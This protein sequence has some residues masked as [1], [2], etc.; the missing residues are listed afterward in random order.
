VL[1]LLRNLLRRK[2]VERDLDEELRATSELLVEEKLRAGMTPEQARRAARLELGSTESLKD[3]VRDV[4]AGAALDM[5]GQDVRY[6]LRLF[7]RAPGFTVV[8]ILTLALGIGANAAIFGVVKSVLVDAL[9]YADADRLVRVYAHLKDGSFGQIQLHAG[10]YQ[11]LA[12]RQRSFDSLAA[13][14]TRRDAVLGGEE[15][16]RVVT[17]QWV[18]PHL[19]RTLGVTAA[20]GRTFQYEDRAL[21]HV[22]ASGAELG[23]DTARSVLITHAAWQGLFAGDPDIVGR[24]LRVNALPRTVIGVLP[25]GF[26]GPSGR[27]DLY[28]AFDIQPALSRGSNWLNLV[29]RL[30]PGVAV[31][32]AQRDVVALWASRQDA[33]FFANVDMAAVPLRD[34]LLGN[35][36]TPLLVL[37]ASAALVLLIACSNLAGALLSRS[38]A[39]R[40]ELAV[41]AALGAGRRRLVRQLLTESTLLALCGGAAGLLLAQLLLSLLRGL[42]A[43]VLPAYARLSLDGGA[44]LVMGLVAICTGLAFGIVPA[45]SLGRADSDGALREEARGASEGR[46]P[47]RLRGALVA[48]QIAL[49]ASLLAGAGLLGRSLWRIAT[50]PLG[51]DARSVLTGRF[52]LSIPDYP[53]P[54]SRA[55]IHE[56]LAE[57]LRS[58]PGVEHVAIAHK[59]PTIDPRISSLAPE[60]APPG[61]VRPL[62]S[63][64][65]V[66]D[67][68]FR[69]LRIPLRAGRGFDA[70]DRESGPGVAVVSESTA[71]RFWPAGQALGAGVRVDGELLSIVGVV[72]DV[73]NDLARAESALMVYRSH[74]QESTQRFVVLIRARDPLA[75]VRPL[76][77]EVKALDPGLPV[78]QP[79]TLEAALGEGLAARR[80]PV[81][82]L[83]GFGALALLLASIGVY[84]MFANLAAARERE[85]GVRIALGSTPGAIALLLLR[86]GAG[87][88]AAG[89]AGGALG[90]ALVARLVRGWLYGI[91]AL[92][93]L[94][95]GSAVALLM[96]C[97]AIALL[98]PVQR[99]TR[100]D[101]IAALR[102]D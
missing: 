69:T 33:S 98:I 84:G 74:R 93:P 8:A 50:A 96:G 71:R 63:Y 62:V 95:L 28:F 61:E 44:V 78:Q 79:M 18:E 59:L 86:Q 2:R 94:A 21:G 42:A 91:E 82:L 32:A 64:A 88:M 39:R 43:P 101:P 49:C 66:S 41:R 36:R 57:R 52:R 7:R 10:M 17:I 16:A 35:T 20:L 99:A 9:P 87:W 73:Q 85:F 3:G 37:L 5:L 22:P 90:I 1:P 27:V 92:D 72:G 19:F 48:A 46:R 15:L 12:A 40:K 24:E 4:R 83:G 89:T 68:Y 14:G 81:L 56:Q 6:A 58:L 25:R 38:L 80:L 100:A 29:A 23:P 30:K 67:D 47:R 102:A 11:E 26:V 54:S 45:L 76:E 77:R 70:T 75:L 31:E 55:R 53:T 51:F 97:A 60:H 34:N 65:S 13:F